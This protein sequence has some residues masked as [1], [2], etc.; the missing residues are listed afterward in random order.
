VC[1][2]SVDKF[3][4]LCDSAHRQYAQGAYAA[5]EKL[6]E[7]ALT[8]VKD[9][10]HWRHALDALGMVQFSAGDFQACLKSVGTLLEYYPDDPVIRLN[11]AV[12]LLRL[13]KPLPA[14]QEM[15][16]ARA[17]GLVSFNLYD[18]LAS[19]CYRLNEPETA[20]AYGQQAL[21]LK[22]RQ[23]CAH[24]DYVRFRLSCR[25]APAFDFSHPERNVIAFSLWGGEPRYLE[26]A[27]RN[28]QLCPHIY[29]GWSCRFY[30]DETVPTD[31]LEALKSNLE[32]QRARG[33]AETLVQIVNMPGPAG[34]A[35]D[36]MF[37]RFRVSDDTGV[38][39][40]LVR[41]ADS[42]FNVKERVSVDD[43]IRSGKMFHIMRDTGAHTELI[44]G[45]LWG[46]VAGVLPAIGDL[47]QGFSAETHTGLDQKF[48]RERVWPL[49]RKDALIH[50]RVY[51]GVLD[52]R[53][54][55]ESGCLPPGR[56]I[57]Q[58]EWAVKHCKKPEGAS[59]NP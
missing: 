28:V 25:S 16:K 1:R 27:I 18:G 32:D 23:A 53:P 19:A 52:G 56:H 22:D 15:E 43:W 24:F 21:I 20:R 9:E 6:L 54:F 31:F 33:H 10:S 7:L 39:R 49:V 57:G 5:A 8:H 37:W 55:G 14:R 46:G 29:P 4:G 44:H 40:F 12:V 47:L 59:D 51:H 34:H 50:D 13:D 35:T 42:L 45:G 17:M 58:N 2:N 36:G 11:Y 26:T 48:L 38:E 3:T 41:D 30:V